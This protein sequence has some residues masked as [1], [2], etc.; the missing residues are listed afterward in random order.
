MGM[1]NSTGA[2]L[3]CWGAL[4]RTDT[5]GLTSPLPAPAARGHLAW[6]WPPGPLS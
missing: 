4:S 3:S 2:P 1:Q 6:A 5:E